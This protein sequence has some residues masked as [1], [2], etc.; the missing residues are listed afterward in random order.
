M[1]R[2]RVLVI[3]DYVQMGGA[4]VVYQQSADL[5]ATLPGVE[6]E[7]FDDSQFSARSTMLSRSWNTVAARALEKT[8]LRFRPHRLMVHNYHNVLSPSILAVIA[9]H[10]RALRYRAYH[11]C[12]DY[13]LVYYNPALQYFDKQGHPIILPLDVLRTPAIFTLR[14]TPKGFVHDLM[15]KT[16]WHAIRAAYRPARVFD[17]IL[18]PSDFMEEALHRSGIRNTVLVHNPSAVPKAVPPVVVRGKDRFNIAF[19][20]RISPE[21][22]LLQFMRLAEA[23]GFER[24]NCIGVYGDGP[25]R[26]AIEQRYAQLIQQRKLIFFGSM[27]QQQLFPAIREFADAVV[28]PSVGAENAP[29]VVIEAA[30]LGLPVLIRDGG[31]MATTAESVGNKIKFQVDPHSLK[32]AL[33][34]LAVHLADDERTYDVGEYLPEHYAERLAEIMHIGENPVSFVPDRPRGRF[35]NNPHPAP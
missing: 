27:P 24:I 22:G 15:T 11:T 2:C 13:H 8:L 25:D 32:Q 31:S 6:V 30:M 16:W 1:Q 28:V 19:V 21:K 35:T 5:L 34:E 9:R 14:P 20:G 26:E 33:N 29:L 17:K 10:Q 23:A 3:N 7:R 18:C 4:E 12:H